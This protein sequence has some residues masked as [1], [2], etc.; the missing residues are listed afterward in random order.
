MNKSRLNR[1]AKQIQSDN[2]HSLTTVLIG[3]FV[4]GIL[5]FLVGLNH[6]S[7]WYHFMFALPLITVVVGCLYEYWKE[8]GNENYDDYNSRK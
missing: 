3:M 1:N 7:A 8:K 5:L 2:Y 6:M 4:V